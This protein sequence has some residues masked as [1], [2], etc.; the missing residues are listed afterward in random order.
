MIMSFPCGEKSTSIGGRN[1]STLPL[2]PTKYCLTPSQNLRPVSGKWAFLPREKEKPKGL[3]VAPTRALSVERSFLNPPGCDS[4]KEVASTT[5][6]STTAQKLLSSFFPLC[7]LISSIVIRR[8]DCFF[9]AT[10][11]V[12]ICDM[13]MLSSA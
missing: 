7:C 3:P 4:R 6:L 5:K 11:E 10:A 1:L 2:L 8:G 13:F 12:G 9:S